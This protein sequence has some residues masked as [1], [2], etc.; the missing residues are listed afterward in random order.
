MRGIGRR[1]LGREGR[2]SR[3]GLVV[4]LPGRIKVLPAVGN[5]AQAK[6]LKPGGDVGR[7]QVIVEGG[8]L[9]QAAGVQGL[10]GAALPLVGGHSEPV[11]RRADLGVTGRPGRHAD[12]LGSSAPSHREPA[13]DPAGKFNE[14][15]IRA[16][17]RSRGLL[18][19]CLA[20]RRAPGGIMADSW[21]AK[22]CYE[23]F[24]GPGPD[25][26]AVSAPGRGPP[27]SAGPGAG[28]G[29]GRSAA[30]RRWPNHSNLGR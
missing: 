5:Q 3:H 16:P 30:W 25:P 12:P 10:L 21:A 17:A 9:V 15:R 7:Q 27:W 24:I 28:P 2:I 23:T 18:C 13:P 1:E 20:A 29:H 11:G 14:A 22:Q 4:Q 19:H 6:E 26:A 8:R